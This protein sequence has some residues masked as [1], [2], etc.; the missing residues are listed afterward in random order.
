MSPATARLVRRGSFLLVG[1]AI[2]LM[3]R[4]HHVAALVCALLF[5]AASFVPVRG[6]RPVRH[7]VD[8]EAS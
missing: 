7:P 8:E 1:A 6:T 3:I 2:P 4:G 5:F